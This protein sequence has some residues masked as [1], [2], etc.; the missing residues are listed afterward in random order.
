MKNF[1]ILNRFAFLLFF[2]TAGF[3]YATSFT[4]DDGVFTLDLPAGWK[5][6]STNGE[7]VVLSL[8]KEN[9]AMDIKS[10]SCTTE[11]CL[12]ERI[13]R[14]L[15]EVRAKKMTVV[16]N[17]YTGEEIKRIDFSTGEPL[18]YISFFT[19]KNDFSAGYFLMNDHA[20]SILAK[21]ITY[22]EADLLFSFFSPLRQDDGTTIAAPPQEMSMEVDTDSPLAY[23]ITALPDVAVEAIEAPI[24]QEEPAKVTDEPVSS[25]PQTHS[26]KTVLKKIRNKWRRSHFT[27]FVH[28]QM[29]PYLRALGHGF[30]VLIAMMGLFG[31]IWISACI[32][33]PF[34]TPRSIEEAKQPNSFYPIRARRLYGTPSLIFRTKD[35]QGNVLISLSS[36]WNSICIC[37]GLIIFVFSIGILAFTSAAQQGNLLN[38]SPL[39]YGTIYSICSL[40][41]PLGILFII[42]GI[43]WGLLILREMTLFDR[44]G[45]KAV[46]V[47]QK[48]FP[49]F[50]EY[51]D[52]HFAQSKEVLHVRR[53][54]FS[55]R[56]CW[57][58]M[59]KKRKVSISFTERSLCK[60]IL[61]RLLGH[62]WG[63]LRTDYLI[64]G[65]E[66]SRGTINST[67]ALFNRLSCNVDNPEAIPAHHALVVTA[68]INMRD[69]DK[70]YPWFN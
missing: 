68:L 56:R 49:V 39:T 9:S 58:I 54:R 21:N 47:L 36:R 45:K 17:T 51:Y 57:Q 11:Q 61:R 46:V 60:S 70:W 35:N 32:L 28:P 33:R 20:Y 66:Q 52:V 22:A 16:S 19:P 59:E 12:D 44:K 64:T 4:S 7:N 24:A 8:R 67:H 2:T 15:A 37:F 10:I 25:L 65:P 40:L 23:D 43:I 5:K 29:P 53:K 30:D 18:F 48:E 27:T 41:L 42:T 50:Y 69:R 34:I 31:L 14:D 63:F 13:N 55:I 6:V 38:F 1:H 3:L 62:L 26:W